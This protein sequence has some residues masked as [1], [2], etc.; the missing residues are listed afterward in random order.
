V[1]EFVKVDVSWRRAGSTTTSDFVIA[2]YP[3]GQLRRFARMRIGAC[4]YELA[5]E[6]ASRAAGRRITGVWAALP[7]GSR[8]STA[9]RRTSTRGR[10]TC[11][12]SAIRSRSSCGDRS[13]AGG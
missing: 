2:L 11:R 4:I 5:L 9:S 12:R 13:V 8:M 10:T 6:Q 7:T 3:D 1:A